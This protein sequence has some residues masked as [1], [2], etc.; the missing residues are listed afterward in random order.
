M[1]QAILLHRLVIKP[2]AI[3]ALPLVAAD[4]AKLGFAPACHVVTPFLQLNRG[5]AVVAPLPAFSLRDLNKL[6]RCVVLGAGP[7]GVPLAVAG[8]AHLHPAAATLGILPSALGPTAHIDVNVARL[9]PLTTAT[10]GAVDAVLGGVFLVFGVPFHLEFE[11]KKLVN[12]LQGNMLGRVAAPGWHM[13]RV[14][15]GECKDAFQA[16]VA[17]AVFTG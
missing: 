8:D 2:G 9:D 16:G 13:L 12:M 11:V 17:H 3:A 5:A 6:P 1:E 15:D 4:H 7:R 10:A 14:C